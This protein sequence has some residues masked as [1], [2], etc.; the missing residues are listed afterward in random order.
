LKTTHPIE[1]LDSSNWANIQLIINNSNRTIFSFFL[2][3]LKL[4]KYQFL[5]KKVETMVWFGSFV[6]VYFSLNYFAQ[7]KAQT[8]S[9]LKT[10][11]DESFS[12]A[13]LY[14]NVGY[15]MCQ[16]ALW[17]IWKIKLEFSRFFSPSGYVVFTWNRYWK[18]SLKTLKRYLLLGCLSFFLIF[19]VRLRSSSTKNPS[20]PFSHNFAFNGKNCKKTETKNLT[21]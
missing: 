9:Y 15:N 8:L 12:K 1:F 5:L 4:F 18:T 2:S 21:K 17:S 11:S 6:L 3:L 14:K 10:Q 16:E 13:E 19:N 7:F 20:E